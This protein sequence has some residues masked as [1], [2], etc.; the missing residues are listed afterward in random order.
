MI[1]YFLAK[2]LRK[3]AASNLVFWMPEPPWKKRPGGKALRL[4]EWPSHHLHQ[5]VIHV[6]KAIWAFSDEPLIK[7]HQV[8]LINI[9]WN[10]RVEQ[11][12]SVSILWHTKLW[13]V[14]NLL[15]ENTGLSRLSVRKEYIVKHWPRILLS[16]GI[17]KLSS[18]WNAWDFLA[19]L[20]P[21][22]GFFCLHY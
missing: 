10:R 15:F 2:H 14:I 19:F 7:Y 18:L 4:H 8:T 5:S 21:S 16:Y 9:T 1:C 12:N 22:F 13:D 11:E 20:G 6:L 3:P 17:F